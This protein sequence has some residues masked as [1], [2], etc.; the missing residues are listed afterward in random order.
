MIK[1]ILVSLDGSSYSKAVVEYSFWL[2]EGFGAQ[3]TGL[4]VVDIVALEGPFI[5]DLSGSL[6]FEPFLNF[7]TKM[8]EVLEAN[9]KTILENF[10][11]DCGNAGV[12]CE[13]LLSFGIVSNEI[14]E[15]SRLSD[16]V[17]IGR[18]GVNVGFEYGILGSA[19]EGV[20]R[21]S[22]RP[23]FIAPAA[24]NAP[25][26]PLLC[27]DGS[28]NSTK[29]MHQAAE[30]SKTLALP[31]TVIT[32]LKGTDGERVL[33]EAR[34]YV[35]PYSIGARFVRT[36]DEPPYSMEGYYRENSHDLVFIGA[37]RHSRLGEMV[38][39]STAEHLMRAVDGPFF[40]VR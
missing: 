1:K 11:K 37:T 10:K 27:Y 33:N 31:L 24:F 16:L 17:V 15:K 9:G 6:G 25:R 14:C 18:R 36:D 3:L 2:S 39:G 20:V 35:A 32:A 12:P 13:T 34:D 5:H 26:N 7:S 40:L 29:A 19:T 23:V 28:P 8:R 4:H 21:K 30:F 22:Q 38:L